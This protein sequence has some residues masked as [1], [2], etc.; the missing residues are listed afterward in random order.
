MYPI[1]RNHVKLLCSCVF[2]VFGFDLW[3]ATQKISI[4]VMICVTPLLNIYSGNSWTRFPSDKRRVRKKS[5]TRELGLCDFWH[6]GDGGGAWVLCNIAFAHF[7]WKSNP[8]YWNLQVKTTTFEILSSNEKII[9]FGQTYVHFPPAAELGFGSG[10]TLFDGR[11]K[12]AHI[13][14]LSKKNSDKISLILVALCS[15]K[16]IRKND[17]ITKLCLEFFFWLQRIKA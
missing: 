8:F 16:K 1:L 5:W 10:V 6:L 17:I 11:Q 9:C 15:G 12:L 3:D 14:E 13:P 4:W 7:Y 2:G